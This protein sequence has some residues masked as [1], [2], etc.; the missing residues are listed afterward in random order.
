MTRIDNVVGRPYRSSLREQQADETR[1]RILDATIQVMAADAAGVSIPAIAREAGVSVPTIYRHFRNKTALMA[2][3][4]PYLGRRAGIGDL[5][6]PATVPEFRQMVVQIFSRLSSLGGEARFAMST[7][8]SDEARRL[9]MPER[10]AASR[11]FAATVMP[12]GTRVEQERLT[13]VL[14]ILS[15][16]AAMRMWL[17]HLGS[18]VDEAADDIDWVLRTAIAS[19]TGRN[20]R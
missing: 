16:S 7:P 1:D 2:A 8:A 11:R 10:I 18:S 9:Q 13:R 4:H 6:K 15:S 20:D 12:R 3:I 14:L 5:V 17:D 19:T